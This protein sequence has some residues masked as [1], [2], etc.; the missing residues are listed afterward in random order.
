MNKL[1]L[2]IATILLGAVLLTA[3]AMAAEEVASG[4]YGDDITWVLDDEGV[5]TISG[6]GKMKDLSDS[7]G[8]A[9]FKYR[10]NIT[11]VIIEPGVTSIGSR[12]FAYC[13]SLT[14]IT[15]PDS[16][17]D[18][19]SYTFFWSGL[20]SVVI[21]DGVTQIGMYTFS[22]CNSLTSVTIP[23]GMTS[24]S[25]CAF[26]GD[27]ALT[28]VTLPDSLIYIG[29]YSF[30]SCTA[31]TSVT[32]PA[33]VTKIKDG[34]FLN[35]SALASITITNPDCVMG[36]DPDSP[37]ATLGKSG[38]T[39]VYGYSGSTAETYAT[40]YG[41][42]FEALGEPVATITPTVT[43]QNSAATIT[44]PTDGWVEG[45]NTFT[46]AADDACV[47][48]VSYNGGETYTRL[49]ATAVDGGYSFTADNMT[50]D[51]TVAIVQ[52]GDASG[53]GVVD[54]VDQAQTKAMALGKLSVSALNQA[55]LDVNK[56]GTVDGIDAAQLKAA[57]LGKLTLSW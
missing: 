10:S 44:A 29:N 28:S 57:V 47:V 32:V 22:Q 16:V 27:S 52:A 36:L 51:T 50:A 56:D 11:S 49:T 35:C 38:T 7:S 37:S 4:T 25:T 41:Y 21:P 18:L 24:I 39:T 55:V 6:T 5:L 13:R 12:A 33:S 30:S 19:G 42:T 17:T 3:P 31:L 23:D 15:I 8:Q 45:A 26:Q 46:V 54:G 14:S 1:L 53:D 43:T 9:W 48:A 34:A 40:S 20:H 2:M